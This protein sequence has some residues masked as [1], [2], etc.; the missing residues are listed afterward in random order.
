LMGIEAA[1]SSRAPSH[2][3]SDFVP[4]REA[5][6]EVEQPGTPVDARESFTPPIQNYDD[7]EDED[8]PTTP[9]QHRGQSEDVAS[10]V[11]DFDDE[12]ADQTF[13]PENP[14]PRS[15]HS[16]QANSRK[17]RKS[18][19][20][21]YDDRAGEEQVEEEGEESERIIVTPVPRKSRKVNERQSA[22]QS[23]DAEPSPSVRAR[24]SHARDK[25]N[26][27][28]APEENL[29][30]DPTP[31]AKAQSSKSKGKSKAQQPRAVQEPSVVPAP[32]AKAQSSK[33]NKGKQPLKQKDAN[34]KMSSR[35]QEQLDD[36]VEKIRAR[37]G[38]PRSLY[39]LRRETPADD[40]VTH[41]RSGR[42]SVRPLAYWRN[43]RCIYGGS[44]GGASLADGARFP[45]NSIKEI[46]RTEE[47]D[48]A[49][50]K[51]KPKQ[52]K[53]KNQKKEK[54][55]GR[56]VSRQ[57]SATMNDTDSSSESESESDSDI[58]PHAEPWET[59][60]GTL[61]GNV[62][63]WDSDEQAPLEQEEEVEI[64]HA[65]AAIKT[66]EVKTS[67]LE[68][69]GRPAFGYAKLLSTKFFGAGLVDLPPG[70][71]KRPKNSRR[72]HMGF[73]VVKGRVTVSVGPIGGEETGSTSRFSI[74][75]G[76]FWQVP[77]GESQHLRVCMSVLL[78][79]TSLRHVRQPIFH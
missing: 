23:P 8:R 32:T 41:T 54:A 56:E 15:I 30:A 61:R 27:Q 47:I 74:G 16:H 79:I 28:Q 22:S 73:Y 34:V 42:V 2:D 76:G 5:T 40:T 52:K 71:I 77:R 64:A 38:P 14:V 12:E 20:F 9:V 7:N 66:R 68:G 67:S 21:E 69:E 11:E 53:K 1:S 46:V 36:I 17:K 35:Q 26:E 31:T 50:E 37:P 3:V 33:P 63:I 39:L 18:S 43:E 24:S 19:I 55:K 51:K 48:T 60:N 59:N 58:D 13:E 75:K 45:L 29:E 70:G 57:P 62:S 65:P 25:V 49:V 4:A 6:L 44:P 72:M 10:L 78:L